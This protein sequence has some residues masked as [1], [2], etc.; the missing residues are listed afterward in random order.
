MIKRIAIIL[1]LII[2]ASAAYAASNLMMHV[3]SSGSASA[4]LT[5]LRITDTGAFRITDT[6]ANRAISP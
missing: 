1:I 6:G 2:S 3:G 5:N 4:P